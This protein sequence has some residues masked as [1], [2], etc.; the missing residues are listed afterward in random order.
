METG[1]II[2]VSV[3]YGIQILLLIVGFCLP[4]ENES[5]LTKRAGSEGEEKQ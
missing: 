2:F 5:E 3:F 4:N 1:L